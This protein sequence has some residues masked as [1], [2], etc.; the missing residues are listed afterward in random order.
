MGL[1][2]VL[3][4]G[5]GSG[6]HVF[7]A[8]AVVRELAQRNCGVSWLGRIEGMEKS[9]V[10]DHG[11]P[12]YGLPAAAVVGR[13]LPQRGV[14]LART[15]ISAVRARGLIRRHGIEVVLGTGG[16]ASAPGVLGAKLAGRPAVLLEPNATAG[17]ANRW[18]SQW[19]NVAAVANVEGARDLKCR[20]QETGVPVRQEFFGEYSPPAPSGPLRILV[21]G[22]SQGAQ[23]LNR[24]VPAALALLNRELLDLEVAHQV[25]AA[26][27]E[28]AQRAYADPLL[29]HLSVE[30]VPFLNDMAGAM[31]KA[32]LVI[33]RAGAITLSEICAM[34]RAALLFPLGLAG[35]HQE[36]NAR[37]VVST[38]GARMLSGKQVT[39]SEVA[40]VLG[41]LLANREILVDMGKTSRMLF[42]R[43]AVTDVADLLA[44]VTGAH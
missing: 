6:G 40:S 26:H 28:D 43:E 30:I 38:G 44:E 22:G 13:G 42:R 36:A 3:V 29:A 33:S 5:G 32:H 20:I 15:A 1:D 24:L 14:A 19:A 35:S 41:D 4:A 17:T 23:Q 11:I 21:L 34:G 18:L 27:L 8:L 2:H 39:A 10:E 16:Y 31:S 9:L 25:G 37:Q 7:P 12:Y